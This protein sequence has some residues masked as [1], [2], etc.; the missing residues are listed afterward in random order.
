M[1]RL[2]KAPQSAT[3]QESMAA[4]AAANDHH[5]LILEQQRRGALEMIETARAMTLRTVK[6]REAALRMSL[7][8]S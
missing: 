6:M 7:L 4:L 1:T 8:P 5:V 3:K 2:D